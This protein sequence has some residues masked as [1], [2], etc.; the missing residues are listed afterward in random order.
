MPS[1]SI[2][3]CSRNKDITDE[4]RNNINE[5]IGCEY[6][7]V[8]VDNSQKVYS[9]FEAYNIGIEKSKAD[10]LC[11][12][13]DDILFQS[14]NWGLKLINLFEENPEYGLVGIAGAKTKTKITSGWWDCKGENMLVNIIQHF[15]DGRKEKQHYGFENSRF[16]EAVVLD[17]VFMALK[18]EIDY[19]FPTNY[20]GFHGYD[21]ILSLDVILKGYKIGITDEIML[22]HF[23]IGNPDHIWLEAIN[24]IHNRYRN[25]LPLS[26]PA[27][28]MAGEELENGLRILNLSYELKEWKIFY[29]HWM[30]LLFLKPDLKLHY[31][32][33]N[34]LRYGTK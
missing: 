31:R 34:K 1:I 6:Q 26:T 32:I 8:I 17:G 3:I 21:L 29:N 19:S 27:G 13:H 18:K 20:T 11:F 23:S 25:L 15:P 9:I 22:E 30:L 16:D 28:N 4:F 24:K 14:K 7:L 2:I 33:F 10:I 5:T 12:V